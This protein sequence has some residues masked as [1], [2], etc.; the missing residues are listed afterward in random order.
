[1]E[2]DSK[3]CPLVSTQGKRIYSFVPSAAFLLG[4]GG[5]VGVWHSLQWGWRVH[6]AVRGY[7]PA[8]QGSGFLPG[9]SLALIGSCRSPVAGRGRGREKGGD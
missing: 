1:M 5:V 6:S 3:Y 9:V 2:T 4:G 8:G 7:L